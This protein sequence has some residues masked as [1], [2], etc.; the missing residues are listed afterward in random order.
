MNTEH[1]NTEQ[2][3][4]RTALALFLKQGI[5][6]TSVDEIAHASGLTRVT[7]YRYFP[8]REQLVLAAFNHVNAPLQRVEDWIAT[9]PKTD[10]DTVMDSIGEELAHLPHGDLS[11]C[12]VEFQRVHPS[13]YEIFTQTRRDALKVIFEWAF[14][15]AE[16]QDRLRPG[17]NRAIVEIYFMEMI[18]SFLE[19]PTP[20]LPGLTPSQFFT[21][22][23]NL[24][25][26]GI[27]KER[28]S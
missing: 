3:I 18:A 24:F 11:A 17:L 21:T 23:K 10:I 26:Y 15:V 5:K 2:H 27:V 4:S 8:Q 9:H 28:Q 16:R 13:V 12:M 25:L 22:L 1:D 19:R 20:L 14:S 6:R 7:V